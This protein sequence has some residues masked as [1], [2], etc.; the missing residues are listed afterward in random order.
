MRKNLK[1]ILVSF[2]VLFGLA[3]G[4]AWYLISSIKPAQLTQLLSSSVKDATGRDLKIM[5]P[6]SLT[7]FPSI[8]VQ[9]ED[10]S[11]SNVSWGFDPEMIKL[12]QVEIGVR[13]LP[14]LRKRVE[15]I[16]IDLNGLDAHLQ[17]D[18]SGQGN[19]IFVTPLAQGATATIGSDQSNSA[20]ENN[21]PGGFISIEN[22]NITD[23]RISYQEDLR[24]QRLFEV[25]RLS[26]LASGDKTAIKLEM[27]HANFD[28]GVKGKVTSIRTILDN[29]GVSPLK[30]DLGLDI[31]LN[32]KPLAVQGEIQKNPKQLPSFNIDLSSKSFDLAPL[33]AGTALAATGGKLPIAA[34]KPKA[35]PK[36]FFSEDRLPLDLLPE[37]NGKINLAIAELGLPDQTPVKNL[38][39]SMTFSGQKIDMQGVSFQ[40]GNGQAK[41]NLS[42]S[43]FHGSAPILAMDGF[44]KGFTLE[45]M[46]ADSKSKVS[47][48]DTKIAFN[49][50]S[51][52][53]SLHQLAG[54]ANGKI[55]ISVGPAML[56]STFLNKGG[57]FAVS[58]FNAINPLRKKLDN[59]TLECAV[60]YLP[61]SNGLVNVADSVGFET[62]LLNVVLAGSVNL[63]NEVINLDIYPREKSGLTSG[64]DLANLIKLQGTLQSPSA[65]IDK[66]AVVKSAV[67]IGLGVLTGG[68]SLLAENAKSLA[69]KSQ[70][71]KN[72]LRPWSDIEAG[73]N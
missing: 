73:A 23:A 11:L 8:G 13:L 24:S 33:L 68:V 30:V 51:S 57:D 31:D 44:A 34:S 25:K 66:A 6:V 53:T 14:L 1:L 43:Q 16:R 9:A 62:N 67:S 72:A 17:S 3:F 49:L 69:T 28:L 46:I 5:G 64:L 55:Q 40:L 32:G 36:Y 15:I 54:N 35:R 21:D 18:A 2:F 48:G 71:C 10:V 41:G 37:A 59:T 60:A 63:K 19:W 29:W 7:I 45:Q 56:T 52:G 61:V 58:V 20:A 27:K 12:K 50:K 39:A 26:L 42:L 22:I 47:G 70:P 4:G 65:G 38:N